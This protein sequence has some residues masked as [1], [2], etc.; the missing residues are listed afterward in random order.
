[1][2]KTNMSRKDSTIPA[3][4]PVI[5]A[6]T[7]ATFH[8]WLSVV[9]LL[10][11]QEKVLVP[12]DALLC[13][14]AVAAFFLWFFRSGRQVRLRKGHLLTGLLMIACL[15]SCIVA[16]F[17]WKKNMLYP[18][19]IYL[20]DTFATLLIIYPLGHYV[21]RKKDQTPLRVWLHANILIW[22]FFMIYVLRIIF[23]YKS[24]AL[25]GGGYITMGKNL[26]GLRYNCNPN[27]SGLVQMLVFLILILLFF[28]DR[29]TPAKTACV[30]L[31]A[32]HY[33]ALVL[34]RSRTSIIT[35]VLGGAVMVYLQLSAESSE[36]SGSS[37]KTTVRK[38]IRYSNNTGPRTEAGPD[39]QT[40][41]FSEGGQLDD[42]PEG[43]QE[44]KTSARQKRTPD[45]SGNR[46]MPAAAAI[47]LVIVLLAAEPIIM[48]AYW[49][50]K[51][52]RANKKKS[53]VQTMEMTAAETGPEASPAILHTLTAL[54]EE[55]DHEGNPLL[56]TAQAART[57]SGALPDKKLPQAAR[58]P[59]GALPDKKLSQAAR[60]TSAPLRD[61]KTPQNLMQNEENT[62]DAAQTEPQNKTIAYYVNRLLTGRLEVWTA[63]LKALVTDPPQRLLT[64][65]SPDRVFQAIYVASGEKH[66]KYAHNQFLEFA[67]TTGIPSLIVFILFLAYT[68][69]NIR[70]LLR[71][72]PAD[73]M[74]RLLPVLF[75]ILLLANMTES[76]LLFY[77]FPSAYVFFFICGWLNEPRK[78]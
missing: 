49:A 17:V 70:R 34:T 12:I 1:M 39:S 14:V 44:R 59:S 50:G 7:A 6:V 29:T 42:G 45:F 10:V 23:S 2:E 3:T 11:K 46:Y 26:V 51:E 37:K 5:A 19:R 47:A 77:Q 74:V 56:I 78:A 25:P 61:K 20:L 55:T 69:R 13:A 35:A 24:K 8:S 66:R 68:I 40:P 18:N 41:W 36:D 64:G 72:R 75:A 48:H 76:T 57:P 43:R 53:A 4:V 60:T 65:T 31:A 21:G 16:C 28:L 38:N 9:R 30:I 62:E 33:T 27:T 73:P 58:T 67:L 71:K 32:M 63:A 52:K 22:T 15:I 54:S